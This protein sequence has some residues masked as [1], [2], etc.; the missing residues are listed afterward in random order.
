MEQFVYRIIPVTDDKSKRKTPIRCVY[1]ND[2]DRHVRKIKTEY[3]EDAR[4]CVQKLNTEKLGKRV[5]GESR[6]EHGYREILLSTKEKPSIPSSSIE[7]MWIYKERGN[8]EYLFS[9]V[10]D[11]VSNNPEIKLGLVIL[12]AYSLAALIY[13]TRIF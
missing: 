2:I 8:I 3:P 4:F 1:R 7:E 12:T 13:K 5:V 6:E 10:V 9:E 11:S